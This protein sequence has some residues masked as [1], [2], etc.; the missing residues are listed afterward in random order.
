MK[1]EKVEDVIG[2]GD[3]VKVKVLDMDSRKNKL[4]MK[5][6]EAEEKA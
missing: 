1:S 2:E 5:A 3:M 4:S 6:V